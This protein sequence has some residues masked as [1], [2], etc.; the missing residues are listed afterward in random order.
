[1]GCEDRLAYE[2][3]EQEAANQNTGTQ[4]SIQLQN[5]VYVWYPAKTT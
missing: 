1:M 4:V 5:K 2:H 3:A